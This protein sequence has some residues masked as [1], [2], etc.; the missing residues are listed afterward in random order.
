[1]KLASGPEVLVIENS[2]DMGEAQ[3]GLAFRVGSDTFLVPQIATEFSATG[4]W[5]HVDAISLREHN[6]QTVNVVI[7]ETVGHLIE[8]D[9]KP[10]VDLEVEENKTKTRI[11]CEVVDRPKCSRL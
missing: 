1:M 4:S 11:R 6:D 3:F 7:S 8:E 9:D 10:S 5:S 2:D